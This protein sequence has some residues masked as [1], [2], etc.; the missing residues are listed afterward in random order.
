MIVELGNFVIKSGKVFCADP[1]YTSDV[2]CTGTLDNVM[3]GLWEGYIT[4][5]DDGEFGERI[6]ELYAFYSSPYNKI[7][8]WEKTNIHGGVASGQFGFYDYDYFINLGTERIYPNKEGFCRRCCDLTIYVET[9]KVLD[10]E[11][12]GGLKEITG[13]EQKPIMRTLTK[14]SPSGGVI[15]T[16]GIVS[17]SGYGDGGY[18]VY[19]T[20]NEDGKIIGFKAVFI[21]E[22]EEDEDE[23]ILE[24]D[25]F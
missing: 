21:D 19:V 2:W 9:C 16:D 18:P 25:F 15:D 8:N 24:E 6:S 13:I 5:I 12:M 3:N 14:Y 7:I 20:K 23:E 10:V 4:K 17:S 11:M 1:C 22:N